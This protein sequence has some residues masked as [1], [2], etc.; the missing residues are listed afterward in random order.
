[1]NPISE[2]IKDILVKEG[3]GEFAST[4]TN[5]WGIFIFEEPDTPPLT[6]TIYDTPSTSDKV[7]SGDDFHHST[8]QIRVRGTSYLDTHEKCEEI[9]ILLHK[10]TSKT[11]GSKET[12]GDGMWLDNVIMD[13]ES[14]PLPSRPKDKRGRFIFVVDGTAYRQKI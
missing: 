4:K 7:M 10:Y 1:M 11:G 13:S 5:E 8:F 14:S 2:I 12:T 3:V 6:V 9:R